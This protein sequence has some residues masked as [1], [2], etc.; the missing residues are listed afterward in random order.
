MDKTLIFLYTV[1]ALAAAFLVFVLFAS[2]Y[3]AG[4]AHH[5]RRTC[6]TLGG[7]YVSQTCF[8]KGAIIDYEGK[9]DE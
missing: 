1:L 3:A 5:D 6:Q 7:V 4:W 9:A 8:H 2:T